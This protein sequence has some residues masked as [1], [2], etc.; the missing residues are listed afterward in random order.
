MTLGLAEA[1]VD[2]LIAYFVTNYPAKATA[3]NAEYNDGITVEAPAD[4][5]VG[6]D[7][8]ERI[9]S[10]PT[11]YAIADTAVF[12]GWS[13][14]HVDAVHTL[15]IGVIIRDPVTETMRRLMYRHARAVFEL[16]VEGKTAGGIGGFLPVAEPSFDFSQTITTGSFYLGDM[17]IELSLFKAEDK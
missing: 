5:F 8:L 1:A 13:S 2:A 3:L 12:E 14:D 11:G 10:Y 16:V 9:Q 17:Q 6:E 15:R 7:T 4:W